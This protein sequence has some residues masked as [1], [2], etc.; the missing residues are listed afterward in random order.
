MSQ[1]HEEVEVVNHLIIIFSKK[2]WFAISLSLIWKIDRVFKVV[3][4]IYKSIM[5]ATNL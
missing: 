3:Y 1:L 2:F 5:V 4:F